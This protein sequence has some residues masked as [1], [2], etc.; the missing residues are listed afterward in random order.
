M[1]ICMFTNTY[2]PHVGGVAR[3]VSAFVEDLRGLGH[4]VLVIAPT[5]SGVEAGENRQE[6]SYR[7]P[8]IQEF[9]GSD[10]SVRLPAP[11]FLAEQIEAF[12]PELIHS[13]HPFLLGDTALRI[14]RGGGLPLVFTHHTLYEN[15]T[16]YVPF[17]SEAMKRFVINLATEYANLC[18]AVIAPSE[19]VAEILRQRGVKQPVE[20]IPTGVDLDFFADGSGERCRRK[21]GIDREALVIGH[22]G[23]LA[24]EKNLPYLAEAVSMALKRQKQARAL[25]AGSG[26]A[27]EKIQRIF[28]QHRVDGRVTFSTG[29]LKGTDLADAY[30][31]MDL[32]VFASKSETQ[33]LVLAEAM[34]AGVPVVA[35]DA[36][37]VREVLADGRNGRMLEGEAA[38]ENFAGA[39]VELLEDSEKRKRLGSAALETAERFS[40]R[41]AVK[42]L[43]EFYGRIIRQNGFHRIEE[44]E[45]TGLENIQ[46][47]L[48]T[49]WELLAEK[50][51]AASRAFED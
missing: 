4:K 33:G 38:P 13:H 47:A 36:S 24:E 48:K 6:G 19:S 10:F 26:D 7:I 31:A 14:A 25:I 35:L 2:L 23:R 34:A 42:K 44:W 43:A 8:S 15:Y 30:R 50:F 27:R 32:F 5:F 51:S 20:V 49:E 16:H 21:L 29:T 11:Y 17:D 37:G 40:R 45:T 46:R 22:V 12:G 9:N 28:K 3:S 18:E 41:L 1:K 39:I